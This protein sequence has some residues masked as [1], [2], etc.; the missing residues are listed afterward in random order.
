MDTHWQDCYGKN[1]QIEHVHLFTENW[2][3]SRFMWM[4]QKNGWKEAEYGS[5]VVEIHENFHLDEPTWFLDHCV[6]GC[7]RREC[8]PIDIIIGEY[9]KVFKSRISAGSTGQIP[10]EKPHAK[11]VAWSYDMEGHARNAL[12]DTATW[13]T[14]QWRSYAKLQVFAGMTINSNRKNLNQLENY[15]KFA[16]KLLSNVCSWND[17]EDQTFCGRWTNLQEQSQNGL[18]HAADDWQDWFHTFIT[19]MEF[20][21]SCHVGNTAQHC[22]LGLFQDSDFAG[23]FEDSKSTSGRVLCIFGSRTFVPIS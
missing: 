3:F 11:T 1:Y 22:R 2:V 7:T 20:R 12:G 13:Q 4:T 19:Q 15:H 10:G 8:K 16:H 21:Q 14:K 6:F 23:G 5:R 18:R 9:T 17:L